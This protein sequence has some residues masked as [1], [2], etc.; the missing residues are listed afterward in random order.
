MKLKELVEVLPSSAW[1]AV[2]KGAQRKEMFRANVYDLFEESKTPQSLYWKYLNMRVLVVDVGEVL[3][4]KLF[5]VRVEM[6]EVKE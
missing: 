2:C 6:E 1:V 4:P 3:K 5:Q